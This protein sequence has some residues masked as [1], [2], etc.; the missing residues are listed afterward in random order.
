MLIQSHNNCETIIKGNVKS[1]LKLI[2]EKKE[3]E[4]KLIFVRV[5][6]W[7]VLNRNAN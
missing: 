3:K 6:D 4:D 5:L 2:V 1:F 7:L